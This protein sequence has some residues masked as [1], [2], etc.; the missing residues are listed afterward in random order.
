[1]PCIQTKVARVLQQLPIF[2]GSRDVFTTTTIV[3][4]YEVLLNSKAEEESKVKIGKQERCLRRLVG[5]N[6]FAFHISV[7]VAPLMLTAFMQRC[8]RR[9]QVNTLGIM[10]YLMSNDI[11]WRAFGTVS[12]SA[13][14]EPS[15]LSRNDRKRPDGLTLIPYWQGGTPLV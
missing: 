13:I 5:V 9:R 7:A 14:K 11:T 12:I 1:M 15:G 6:F 8:E 10:L 3:N 2:N 4:S